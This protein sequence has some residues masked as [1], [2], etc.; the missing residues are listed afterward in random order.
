MFRSRRGMK[1]EGVV[2]HESDDLY[3]VEELNWKF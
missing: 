1:S 2:L 3:G